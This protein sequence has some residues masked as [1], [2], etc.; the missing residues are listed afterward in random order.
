MRA[1]LAKLLDACELKTPSMDAFIGGVHSSG[2]LRHIHSILE[3]SLTVARNLQQGVNVLVHCS[4]GWDRT[5]QV[6]SLAQVLVDPYYR[7]LQGLQAL[8]EKDWLSF[9]H[10]FT[11]RCGFLQGDHKETAPVFTQLVD[12][13]W[14]LLRAHPTAFQFSERFL[15][16]LHDHVYSS[17]FG[18]FVGNCE[19]DRVDLKLSQRTYS[20]WGQVGSRLDE[21][22]NPLYRADA[23]PGLLVPNLAPAAVHFWRGLYCRFD[24]G[25]HPRESVADVLLAAR[26]HSMSME[27][28]I[29]CLQQRIAAV[30]ALL[31]AAPPTPTEPHRLEAEVDQSD[32]NRLVEQVELSQRLKSNLQL[33]AA[34]PLQHPL[35][36]LALTD[37]N[38]KDV[39]DVF[40]DSDSTDA[41]LTSAQLRHEIDSVAV[42]WRSLRAIKECVC[43]TPFDHFSKKSHC[44]RC[45]EVFCT[46]CLDKQTP[47]P[48]HLNQRPA[49]VCRSCYKATRLS[50]T[51][52]TSP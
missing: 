50:S 17:Q 19:K 47:L 41:S 36:D 7:T 28:H 9:G 30:K 8:I 11:D 2:W 21:Y 31:D 25:V 35:A 27:L 5:A 42:D 22:L 33:V 1:S 10:K 26:D 14:Q 29:S 13:M 24:S 43:S 38:A 6:C 3:T 52:V 39:G 49:P 44:W 18:T 15:L 34:D 4:D 32:D 40:G 51:S 48:G 23:Q 12:A 37:T 20:L 16:H 46:R 45:G